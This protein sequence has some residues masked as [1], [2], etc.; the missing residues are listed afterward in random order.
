MAT[1]VP[2]A[3]QQA[4]PPDR[5]VLWTGRGFPMG[6]FSV[7]STHDSKGACEKERDG[8]VQAIRQPGDNVDGPLK[9]L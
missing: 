9:E 5:H 3:C 6:Q 7:V 4:P 8:F 1:F 2:G